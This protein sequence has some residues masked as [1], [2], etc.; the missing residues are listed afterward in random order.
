MISN[1]KLKKFSNKFDVG[2]VCVYNVGIIKIIF[3]KYSLRITF[4]FK[5]WFQIYCN[6]FVIYIFLLNLQY[7]F[8]ILKCYQ[9]FMLGKDLW[10]GLF[11]KMGLV[12]KPPFP[13]W[14]HFSSLPYTELS[15]VNNMHSFNKPFPKSFSLGTWKWP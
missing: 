14:S 11:W 9:S 13:M 7:L 12:F 2:I 6:F 4:F 10:K 3:K 1:I 15:K 5:M 8:S